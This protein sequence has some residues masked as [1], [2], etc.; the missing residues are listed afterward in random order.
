MEKSHAFDPVGG[1]GKASQ[2][3]FIKDK[4]GILQIS[5]GNMLRTVV[6]V[7]S[8]SKRVLRAAN[9]RQTS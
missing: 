1:A 9:R 6:T 4:F 5:T 8:A 7:G 2:V 3:N